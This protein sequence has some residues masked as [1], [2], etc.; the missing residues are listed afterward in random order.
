M[1]AGVYYVAGMP[2]FA[3]VAYTRTS[4][5][6]LLSS[7]SWT[8]D[9]MRESQRTVYEEMALSGRKGKSRLI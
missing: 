9:I 4:E 1:L 3:T 5:R 7:V 6:I 8:P 2:S